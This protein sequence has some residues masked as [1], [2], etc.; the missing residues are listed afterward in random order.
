M[1]TKNTVLR[2]SPRSKSAVIIRRLRAYRFHRPQSPK[3]M[4]EKLKC[5]TI[6]QLRV[7]VN[8][9][10]TVRGEVEF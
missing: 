2:R 7:C 3:V 4:F 5:S 10:A 1:A 9:R 6:S 8:W